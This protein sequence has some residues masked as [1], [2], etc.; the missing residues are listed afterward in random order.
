MYLFTGEILCK[1]L[2]WVYKMYKNFVTTTDT[3]NYGGGGLLKFR[4]TH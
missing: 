1:K 2:L 4:P 3:S